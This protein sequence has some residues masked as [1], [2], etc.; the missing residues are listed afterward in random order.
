M[1]LRLKR[2]LMLF[3]LAFCGGFSAE[4]LKRFE[5]IDE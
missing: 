5:A 1:K 3:I 4:D 2:W